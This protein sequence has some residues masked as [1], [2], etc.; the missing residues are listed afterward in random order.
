[1]NDCEVFQFAYLL[2]TASLMVSAGLL[3]YMFGADDER[4]RHQ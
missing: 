4:K 2:L 3:G 1:M